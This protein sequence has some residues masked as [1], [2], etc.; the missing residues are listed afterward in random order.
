MSEV[1]PDCMEDIAKVTEQ[2][3]SLV[4]HNKKWGPHEASGDWGVEE[5]L[6]QMVD[7]KALGPNGFM[8]NFFHIF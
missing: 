3:P 8:I 4:T 5:D 6:R 7:V 2:I 1:E